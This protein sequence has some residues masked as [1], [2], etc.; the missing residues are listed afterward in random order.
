MCHLN[1]HQDQTIEDHQLMVNRVVATNNKGKWIDQTLEGTMNV[2][3]KGTCSLKATSG[4]CNILM[5][6][7]LNHLSFKKTRS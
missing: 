2:I 3:E 5:T 7:F 4:S 6:S 1:L